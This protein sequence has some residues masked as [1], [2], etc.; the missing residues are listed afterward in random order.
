MSKKVICISLL[1]GLF[2]TFAYSQTNLSLR[3]GAGLKNKTEGRD[4]KRYRLLLA[5]DGSSDL[6]EQDNMVLSIAGEGEFSYRWYDYEQTHDE[7]SHYLKFLLDI[8]PEVSFLFAE[9]MRPS[10]GAGLTLGTDIG[11]YTEEKEW[12]YESTTRSFIYGLNLQPSLTF[13]IEDIFAKVAIKYRYLFEYRHWEY[14]F[15]WD[16]GSS[17][18]K[19]NDQSWDILLSAGIKMGGISF[20][21]GIQAENWVYKHEDRDRWPKWPKDW[22]FML[23]AKLNT[24]F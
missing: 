13:E 12:D 2:P 21:A 14:E 1:L 8:R 15:E 17:D 9:I 20:E 10:F 16:E 23:F 18:D 7:T 4:Y 11:K 24:N 19:Y 6:I 3:I 22:E 5:V